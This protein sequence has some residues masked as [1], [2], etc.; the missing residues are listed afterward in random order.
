M[1]KPYTVCVLLYGDY[2]DLAE[3]V[4]SS[5]ARP[6]FYR[7]FF[8]RIGWQNLSP[9]SE[10]VLL[11]YVD[12]FMEKNDNPILAGPLEVCMKGQ[13]PYHKYPLMRRLFYTHPIQSP[14]VMW[15]DDDSLIRAD[16]PDE[17]FM[18][19]GQCMAHCD[20][21]GHIWTMKVRGGQRAYIEDQPWY[22]G[23]AIPKALRFATGGWWTIRTE[24]LQQHNWPPEDLE[25]NGGDMMLGELCRQQGYRLRNYTQGLGINCD[26]SL[27][28][29]SA[30]RRGFSQPPIGVR[31]KRNTFRKE[32]K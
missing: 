7:S 18:D 19:V 26:D 15:F 31:Y 13:E 5:L 8:L 2:P 22:N 20:M 3:R 24:I 10:S 27:V 29:S 23:K 16:A 12:I 1:I 21:C 11:K 32:E 14:Y 6:V 30:E 25:H 28:G 17:F 4:L 9:A